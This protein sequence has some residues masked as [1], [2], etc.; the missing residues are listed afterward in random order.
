MLA[1]RRAVE[2]IAH[3]P[4]CLD[5]FWFVRIL[6][7]LGPQSVNVRIDR[8]LITAVAI[9]PDLIQELTARIN[10]SRIAREVK[11]EVEL[12]RSEI[13]RFGIDGDLT[14]FDVDFQT[15]RFNQLLSGCLRA[16]KAVN[17]AEDGLQPG[18]QLKHAERLSEVVVCAH[19]ESEH[20]IQ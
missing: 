15:G 7:D 19:L 20:A 9:A 6:F 2:L 10:P 17:T 18:Y 1:L 12:L 4:N 11:Q 3:A 5:I 16:A 14:L 8:V 13:D